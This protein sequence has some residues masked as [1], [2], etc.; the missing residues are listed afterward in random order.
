MNIS[1]TKKLILNPKDS[2][3]ETPLMKGVFN[4]D[5]KL[6]KTLLKEKKNEVKLNV[7]NSNGENI[8]HISAKKNSFKSLIYLISVDKT[9]LNLMNLA[10][11]TSRKSY[12]IH[13]AIQNS[14]EEIFQILISNE[15]EVN[16][17]DSKGNTPL[18]YAVQNSNLN[19]ATRLLKSKAKQIKNNEG[20][21]PKKLKKITESNMK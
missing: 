8:F 6:L 20:L 18:H 10:D 4:D 15:C 1:P 13:V 21:T 5:V 17:K 19:Y 2:N 7:Q 11:Y 16:V 9:L 3:G 14:S 12:P